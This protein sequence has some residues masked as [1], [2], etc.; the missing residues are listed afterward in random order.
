M[1]YLSFVPGMDSGDAILC[2]EDIRQVRFTVNEILRLLKSGVPTSIAPVIP[3]SPPQSTSS[4]LSGLERK[5]DKIWRLLQQA[6]VSRST[7][8]SPTT[9]TPSTT[10]GEEEK[11][12]PFVMDP[13]QPGPNETLAI[14]LLV[15]LGV[16]L[17]IVILALLWMRL[18]DLHYRPIVV[19]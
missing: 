6:N 7:T 3:A 15:S 17:V 11:F 2:L 4:P 1:F 13:Y 10:F 5:V 14:L 8:E 16:W 19:R 18:A 9:T 12:F